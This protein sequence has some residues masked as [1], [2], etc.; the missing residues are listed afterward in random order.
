MY[1]LRG[2]KSTNWLAQVLIYISVDMMPFVFIMSIMITGFTFCFQAMGFKEKIWEAW[3][4]HSTWLFWGIWKDWEILT[5][6]H[7]LYWLM[8]YFYS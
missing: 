7:T 5:N 6:F 4:L 1:Y 3:F 8:F 2:V